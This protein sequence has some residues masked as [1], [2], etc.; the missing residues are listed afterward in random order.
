MRF[1]VPEVVQTSEMDCGPAALKALLE[2][3]GIHVSY[4]RLREACQTHVDGTS[5]DAIEEV[6]VQLG[7]DAEQVMLPLDHLTLPVAH[8]LPALVVVLL[9]NG[10]T[11]FVIIWR[12]H[13]AFVQIMDPGL[14][15]R[16]LSWRRFVDD[17]FV[18]TFPAPASDWR[19]WAGSEEFLAPLRERLKAL[20]VEDEPSDALLQ[21]ALA[22]A[23]W[24][25]LARLDAAV[26][27]VAA[28]VRARGLHQ[29]P[30]AVT[31][32]ERL[33]ADPQASELIPLR[34]WFVRPAP[35]DQPGQLWLRGA[36]LVRVKG[37]R[38]AA[39]APGDEA[40][41]APAADE[42]SPAPLP[43][44][45]VAALAERPVHPIQ[46]IWQAMQADGRL[47][48][49]MLG[50]GL[51]MAT[52]GVM[53][54]AILLLGVVR[55]AQ[56]TLSAEWRTWIMG[57]LMVLL[58]ALF[59]LE[60]PIYTLTWRLAR[61]VDI[62]LR[63]LLLEKIP[64]LND[65]YFH[66]RLVSDMVK[67]AH[68]LRILRQLPFLM[69][70]FARTAFQLVL[71]TIG[72]IILQPTQTPLI[73]LFVALVM[74]FSY[75]VTLILQEP[76]LR[77]RTHIGA[78]SRVYLDALLGLLPL[79]T[80]SAERVMRR[81]HETL[82]SAWARSSLQFGRLA[83]GLQAA[84]NLLFNLLA[85]LLIFR[86]FS[87]AGVVSSTVLLQ[88]YW[89]L[90][91]V[92][93]GQSTVDQARR[94]PTVRNTLL[95]LLEILGTPEEQ[96][97]TV[98]QA[99]SAS[100]PDQGAAIQFEGVAVEAGGHT[101]LSDI[102]LRIQAGEH[103]AVIGPSGAGKSTL[104][105]LLLG[106]HKPAAGECRVDGRPLDGAGLEALR[107]ETA[108]V[109]PA[110]QLW[111]RSLLQ[112]L[113]YGHAP[114]EAEA[115]VMIEQADLFG[116]LERLPEGLQTPL[117]ESGGLVSG[118]EGQRVRLGRALGR[119]KAR[120]VILDE[121]FRGL[122]REKRRLLLRRAREYWRGATL[123]CITH[124]VGETQAFDRVVII[125]NGRISEDNAPAQL[126]A[127]PDSRY[128][129]LLAAEQEVRQTLWEGAAWR[130]LWLEQGRLRENHDDSQQ[131]TAD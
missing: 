92:V 43:P 122:D 72:L 57:I 99:P 126:A 103:I 77:L 15:R 95:R 87:G 111:N 14:G 21:S 31:L 19:A 114:S 46:T 52:I 23:T 108:W 123:I 90:N 49:T 47:S 86:T 53:F 2:G 75:L 119:Q 48:L 37:L 42:A 115:S 22:D 6:A 12:L 96:T 62:R 20:V 50:L 58:V 117:G 51:V 5:I 113:L 39:P 40:D 16:W 112:N 27:L 10:M 110:V 109:D 69:T 63:V 129:A 130:R 4:G 127:R 11:H 33:C 28:L 91:L 100:T 98:G 68:D 131:A 106:W 124:D 74:G 36:V 78:L 66:S 67:R 125:E 94:Y 17:I 102:H 116:V 8:A 76:E 34:F 71:T 9:P 60:V 26:R 44:E 80:H 118:G 45:L 54:E 55:L 35:A 73:L 25:G 107:R 32:L 56:V 83:V 89:T 24:S 1:L 3:H 101:I 88:F 7:L 18:H 120:L 104:V 38:S 70:R 30:E 128:N 97:A 82:V 84:T 93:L 65:R 81:E 64:K 61:R 105:G 79:R 41:E 85:V 59:A 13:G 29:G 121:P